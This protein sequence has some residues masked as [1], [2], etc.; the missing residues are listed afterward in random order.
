MFRLL[1]VE[2][3]FL[4]GAVQWIKQ[5]LPGSAFPLGY[6]ESLAGSF[7]ETD[8]EQLSHGERHCEVQVHDCIATAWR[9][10]HDAHH[11]FD[12]LILDMDLSLYPQSTQDV[13]VSLDDLP[14]HLQ[15]RNPTGGLW[16]W[17][18][19]IQQYGRNIPTLFFTGHGHR[20]TEFLMPLEWANQAFW[21]NKNLSGFNAGSLQ[22][23]HA[24]REVAPEL[25]YTWD[26]YVHGLL[27][28]VAC[29]R[30]WEP[31][32]TF[33]E[34]DEGKWRVELLAA[35]LRLAS[36]A[37]LNEAE[38]ASLDAYL[39]QFP[40]LREQLGWMHSQE[41][42]SG[43]P[44]YEPEGIFHRFM[45]AVRR[46]LMRER[47]FGAAARTVNVSEPS[48]LWTKLASVPE[49][50]GWTVPELFPEYDFSA[51]TEIG[52][53][54]LTRLQEQ[55]HSESQIRRLNSIFSGPKSALNW[56]THTG[57][58]DWEERR[59][60][61]IDVDE[62]L[63]PLRSDIRAY[64]A[65]KIKEIQTSPGAEDAKAQAG[66]LETWLRDSRRRYIPQLVRDEL[67]RTL[68]LIQGDYNGELSGWDDRDCMRMIGKITAD[69]TS[70]VKDTIDRRLRE[71]G[72]SLYRL[73]ECCRGFFTLVYRIY[74]G[75]PENKVFVR[76]L[77]ASHGK[78]TRESGL[79]TAAVLSQ[80]FPLVML[81]VKPMAV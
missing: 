36:R 58:P 65:H 73:A 9:A 78:W 57:M 26:E 14:S 39:V 48:D 6:L 70:I 15:P 66:E 59:R 16:L 12:G 40:R 45:D 29:H 3:T 5:S 18:A 60:R 50:W 71:E 41:R 61:S 19:A 68:A 33:T 28:S 72:G 38:A 32:E 22:S 34:A 54:A 47:F 63:A 37:R 21:S 7:S 79:P 62:V 46:P 8:I 23:M 13:E 55:L 64:L 77:L 69:D 31:G 24:P 49:E 11:P 42:S 51:T 1:L 74:I 75:P 76:N 2:D 27:E 53:T 4:P 17:A 52:G 81:E 67:N 25:D 35:L 56:L 43:V 30:E 80:G 10:I 20:Y 44:W